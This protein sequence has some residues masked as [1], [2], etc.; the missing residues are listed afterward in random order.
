MTKFHST[1]LWTVAFAGSA[2]LGAC[3]A[4][5]EAEPAP[6]P[7][8]LTE[9]E[10]NPWVLPG[11]PVP[12]ERPAKATA[13]PGENWQD[14][15]PGVRVDRTRRIVEV[16]GKVPIDAHDAEA[17]VVYLEAV[18]CTRDTREHESLVVSTGSPSNTHAALLLIGL[19]PGRPGRVGWDGQSMRHDPPTGPAVTLRIKWTD[20]AGKIHEDPP[21][22][23]IVNART[24]KHLGE[25]FP[26]DRWVFSGSRFL[27]RK[28]PETGAMQEIYDADFAGTFIGL[29]TFGAE[30]IAFTRP[31]NPDA[32]TEAP[33]W[34]ADA[35]RVPKF[36]TPVVMVIT[37]ADAAA[38]PVQ[39][40]AQPSGP[41]SR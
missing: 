26:G 22:D 15:G 6:E 31:M 9:D 21:G 1:F 14:V 32:G 36:G 2:M 11:P 16:T 34:V 25:E 41:V 8:P 33:E 37:P 29:H 38:K 17:P 7:A 10:N 40:P 27:Q 19:E 3:A 39:T 28:N 30:T 4:E 35:K 5:P 18:A 12:A 13:T 24:G 20:S 23:W